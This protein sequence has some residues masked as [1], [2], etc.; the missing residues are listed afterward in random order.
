[1]A[2]LAL[3]KNAIEQ[4]KVLRPDLHWHTLSAPDIAA[5]LSAPR[6]VVNPEA[7]QT[8]G[9]RVVPKQVKFEDVVALLPPAVIVSI[10]KELGNFLPDLQAVI[11]AQDREFMGAL[12]SLA[13]QVKGVS[14]ESAMAFYQALEVAA[15]FEDL[16]AVAIAKQDRAYLMKLLQIGMAAQVI[17]Q[18]TLDDLAA[19]LSATETV[20]DVAPDTLPA[21]SYSELYELGRVTADDVFFVMSG[22]G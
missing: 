22:L 9:E 11:E 20:T 19:L 6:T 12:I 15:T 7:G 17:T 18:E 2:D 3:L 16:V 10:Y 5:L 4:V 13:V 21:P 14:V 1:M 8:T